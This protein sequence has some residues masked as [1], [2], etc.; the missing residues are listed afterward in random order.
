MTNYPQFFTSLSTKSSNTK[1][2]E[3]A[4]STT[5]RESCPLFC[6]L[7]LSGCYADGYR[8]QRHWNLVTEQK[9]GVQ[10]EEFLIQLRKLHAT[11]MFRHN[12]AGD[13]IPKVNNP[14]Q[15]NQQFLTEL[16][17]A[18]SHLFAAW[19]YTHHTLQGAD[20]EVNRQMILNINSQGKFIV[21]VS[22]ESKDVAAQLHKEGFMVTVV[23]PEG[24]PTAFRH[25]G[26]SFVQCPATL[27]GS[28]ITCK[29]CGG[30]R[31]KPLCARKRDVVVVFP[32]HGTRK[33]KAA[34]KCS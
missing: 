2:G 21:N 16:F 6:A 8:T 15:I 26:V 19:T 32:A 31:G 1:T 17:K 23:Q 29:T 9:R 11:D 7:R 10:P 20:G 28:S 24:L 27:D 34:E 4:V 18:T 22:T 33:R 5:S 12:V 3:I 25:Q 30:L 14:N 13:L